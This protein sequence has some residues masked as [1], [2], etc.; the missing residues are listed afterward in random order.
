MEVSNGFHKMG[1]PPIAGWVFQG[2]P[3]NPQSKMDA[4]EVPLLES[5]ILVFRWMFAQQ[6]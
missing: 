5:S 2:N 6:L 4:L 3:G 1:V